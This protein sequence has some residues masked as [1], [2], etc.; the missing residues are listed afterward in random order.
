MATISN[1][2]APTEAITSCLS[3]DIFLMKEPRKRPKRRSPQ[4]KAAIW[5]ALEAKAPPNSEAYILTL[6][7]TATSIPT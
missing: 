1:A 7:P 6:A 4:Y 5:V 3:E 2:M